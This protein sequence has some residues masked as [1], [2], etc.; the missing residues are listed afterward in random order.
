MYWVYNI[1][2]VAYWI[3]QIPILIYRLIFEDGFY[4]R[5]KQSAGIMPTPTLQQIAYHNA[6]W[7]HAAS[8]GEVVAASPIVRE[9]KKKY[10]E[11]MVVVSVVTATGHR[12]AQKIIP[13]ADG[14]IF[15]PFDLPVITERIV[16]IVNPKAI[17][18]IETELWPN[19]LRLAWKRKIPVMMMNGRISSRSMKRYS[20]VKS[21][22]T[23]MLYQITKF[24]MQ[25]SIDKKR[26]IAMGALPE[27]VTITGNTKYDQTYAEVSPEERAALRKKFR[28]DGKGPIIV[29]GSTH[30]GEEE[31][32]LRTYARILKKHPDAC[33]LLAVREIT[34]APSVKFMIK[35]EGYT[36]IR[37][38]RM[39]TEEDDG[40]PAQVVILDTIGELGR[41]YSLADLVF[42]GGSFVKVGGHNILEPAAHGKPVVV[43]PY[44]FN[45]Q[46]IFE[47]LSEQN[48]CIMAKNEEEFSRIMLDLLDHPEKLQTMGRAALEVVRNNQGATERNIHAF[49][50]LV[51]EW[52]VKLRKS[53][54]S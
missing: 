48:V 54:E 46:E 49:E 16:N 13:E 14:H 26:I 36:V 31:I 50:D 29:A 44:M 40:K 19:F 27:R 12:M 25:S 52:G 22:T 9:L 8:V 17:I 15:F 53:N 35:R 7:V 41:L 51:S 10:P 24:C 18:L 30:S 42:V 5:L 38:S 23:R 37:R 43:G 4:D 28:F 21:F 6:I 33:L 11:E 32:L 2:L 45:F 34:R 1:C 3:L 47:L 39:G 20:L